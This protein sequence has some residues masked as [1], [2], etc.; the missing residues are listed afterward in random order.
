MNYLIVNNYDIVIKDER[1]Y[2]P[3]RGLKA[4]GTERA[5][6]VRERFADLTLNDKQVLKKWSEMI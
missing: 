6:Y 1:F 3:Y 4:E 5:R 2:F